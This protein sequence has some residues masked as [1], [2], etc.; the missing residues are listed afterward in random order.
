MSENQAYAIV[1]TSGRQYRV[2]QGDKIVVNALELEKGA[3]VNLDKVVLVKTADGSSKIGTPVVDGASVTARVT[4]NF[5][6]K[7]VITF[8]KVRR[9]GYTKKQG[10]RQ[11]VTE[12]TIESIPA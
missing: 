5:R 3:K 11:D 10:H 8:K 12:L 9:N 2:K 4:R 7:K 1:E 6:T